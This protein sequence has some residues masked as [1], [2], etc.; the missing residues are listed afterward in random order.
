MVRPQ[1]SERSVRT[2]GGRWEW[3]ETRDSSPG[4]SEEETRRAAPRLTRRA[5]HLDLRR[6]KQPRRTSLY[7]S[8]VPI[9]CYLV[10]S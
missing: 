6:T 4:A 1:E 5:S 2:S 8:A 7:G 9:F 10:L 3:R